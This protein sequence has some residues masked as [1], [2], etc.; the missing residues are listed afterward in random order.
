MKDVLLAEWTLL[1]ERN[2]ARFNRA[3]LDK[4]S[5]QIRAV[6]IEFQGPRRRD[7]ERMAVESGDRTEPPDQIAELLRIV[8]RGI[9]RRPDRAREPR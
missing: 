3:D 6:L 2:K 5:P 4:I 1:L 9:H 8:E 7:G